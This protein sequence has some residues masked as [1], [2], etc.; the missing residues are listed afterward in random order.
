MEDIRRKKRNEYNR[1]LNRKVKFNNLLTFFRKNLFKIII[2][3]IL[4]FI[5]L[6]PDVTGE[7]VGQWVNELVTSFTKNITF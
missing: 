3:I 6:Y 4:V 1:K 5:I 7:V 2:F